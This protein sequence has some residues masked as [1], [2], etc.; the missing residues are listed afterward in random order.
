[1]EPPT[2]TTKRRTSPTSERIG[3]AGSHLWA[4]T[5]YLLRL[6]VDALKYIGRTAIDIVTLGRLALLRRQQRR[7]PDRA[8]IYTTA[9][10]A[11]R[12]AKTQRW[13]AW[14]NLP[15]RR[16][17]EVRVVVFTMLIV[18][19]I[20]AQPGGR[21]SSAETSEEF[22]TAIQHPQSPAS[23]DQEN[24]ADARAEF[25]RQVTQASVGQW[26]LYPEAVMSRGRLNAW[27]DFKVGSPVVID[28]G[29]SGG[30]WSSAKQSSRYRMWYRGC[31]FVAREYACGVGHATS[32]DGLTWEKLP[33]P[34]FV[35][36]DSGQRERL[37]AIAVVRAGNHYFMWYAV[38]ADWRVG[39]RHATLHLATSP[40]GREWTVAGPVLRAVTEGTWPLDPTASYDGRL[41]HLW[42]VDRTE[43]PHPLSLLHVTSADGRQWQVAGSTPLRTLGLEDST[44]RVSVTA[45]P[46]GYLAYFSPR[47]QRNDGVLGFL[48]SA[49][50]NTW[51]REPGT[52]V[53]KGALDSRGDADSPMVIASEGGVQVWLVLRPTDGAEAIGFAYHK[54]S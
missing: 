35:P 6:L 1:M 13:A 7:A 24:S 20:W 39:T 54:Q 10:T 52:A 18:F 33:G 48:R 27:D 53:L 34:V 30:T 47:F 22:T 28:E 23:A 12:E 51:T 45:G 19:V 43:A 11:A 49:D 16:R 26:L 17:V 2:Q 5:I 32:A 4:G 42:Y 46:S 21:G 50:G 36:A 40:D 8:A 38:K 25:K 3:R 9:A 29:G 44:R 15:V 37:D 31:H 14:H 41:F